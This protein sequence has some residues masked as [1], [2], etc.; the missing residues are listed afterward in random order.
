MWQ[1]YGLDPSVETERFLL[2]CTGPITRVLSSSPTP[3]GFGNTFFKSR[4]TKELAHLV[5][6]TLEV[7]NQID[8]D[9]GCLGLKLAHVDLEFS[10][11]A[12][13]L[14]LDVPPRLPVIEDLAKYVNVGLMPLLNAFRKSSSKSMTTK[15]YCLES[16][17]W[18]SRPPHDV[19]TGNKKILQQT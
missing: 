9:N 19:A 14:Y 1:E 18:N 11:T 13:R 12:A 16:L 10:P 8:R 17:V 15:I 7:L 4:D 3:A 2:G 6:E 5:T